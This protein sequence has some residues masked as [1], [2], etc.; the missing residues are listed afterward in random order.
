MEHGRYSKQLT[1]AYL[2][3]ISKYGYPPNVEQTISYITEMAGMGFSSIE[4]EGIGAENIRYLHRHSSSIREAV[5]KSGCVVPVYCVV[6]PQLSSPDQALQQQSLEL[7][8]LG[9]QTAQQLGASGVLDN[10]PL[11]PLEY[12]KNAP[13]LRHYSADQ[14][15]LPTGFNWDQ[16]WTNLVST[17]QEACAIAASYNLAYHMHPCEGSLITGTDSF[18]YFHQAVQRINLFFNLDT[19]N[20]FYRKD[21]LAL[22]ITRLAGKISYIHVSDNGGQRVEHLVPGDGKIWWSGFFEAL[23]ETQFSGQLAIDVG[24]AESGI[25]DIDEAYHRSADWLTQQIATYL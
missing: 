13:I 6:L 23:R 15:R 25:N 18:L 7:F 19:A 16:Y 9:C 12:P 11:L 5:D 14:L 10:G 24:G 17:Y 4:L 22:C 1:C 3:P 20:Q 21:D 8:R 2:Y